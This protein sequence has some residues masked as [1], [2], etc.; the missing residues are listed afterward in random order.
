MPIDEP[1]VEEFQDT[2]IL[3][4]AQQT[5][6]FKPISL[7]LNIIEY[8]FDLLPQ[9]L[10]QTLLTT[11][12]NDHENRTMLKMFFKHI[13]T[14]TLINDTNREYLSYLYILLKTLLIYTFSYCSK[15]DHIEE[16]C[17]IQMQCLVL[18]TRIC[19]D[20]SY[21]CIDN[22]MIV[23]YVVNLLKKVSFQKILSIL[24]NRINQN[25]LLNTQVHLHK[26]LSRQYLKQLIQLIEEII[27]LEYIILSNDSN[28]ISQPIVSQTIFI[29]IIVQYLKQ[30]QTIENHRYM[31]D[32]IVRILP[33]CGSSLKMISIK[34]IEQICRNLC[35]LV[36]Y[37]NQQNI[38]T[39]FKYEI[40]IRK[41]DHTELI[42]YFRCLSSFDVFYYII[43]FIQRLSYIC[44]YCLGNTTNPSQ[45][46][47]QPLCPLNWMKKV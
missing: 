34:I 13:Q 25:D 22:S 5:F 7:A 41:K 15:T 27:L 46:F 4:Y 31:I 1:S 11:S 45:N 21:K 42:F 43:Y 36:Q 8:L 6:N 19:H 33:H 26:Q 44:N 24:F 2:L 23:N 29:S 37:Q 3:L 30:I 32:L 35:F 9:Q 40:T 28:L 16:N 10:I 47:N 12:T 14:F 39:K 17:Q 18:L 38:K 20:L